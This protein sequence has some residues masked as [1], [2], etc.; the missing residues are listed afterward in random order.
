MK[1]NKMLIAIPAMLAVVLSSCKDDDPTVGIDSS[2]PA[3]AEVSYDEMNSSSS[4]IGVYWDA[5]AA[6][7]SGATSFTVQILKKKDV[8]GDAYDNT[9]S[10]TLQ[11]SDSPYDASQFT[12]L[13][14]GSKYF[15]RV[16]ANYPRSVYS[17]WAYILSSYNV[18]AKVKVGTGVMHIDP[19]AKNGPEDVTVVPFF[20]DLNLKWEEDDTAESY[21]IY[22]DDQKVGETEELSY[23]VTGLDYNT[24]YSVSVASVYSDGSE[25]K[26]DPEP[27]KTGN[28]Q[29]ITRNVG[30]THLSVNWDDVS[31]G[32]G[33][34]SRAY[35]VELSNFPRKNRWRTPFIR[36]IA[37]TVK[38]RPTVRSAAL[39]GME[40]RME[41][42]F[43]LL[44]RSHSVSWNR[45]RP[46]IS[47]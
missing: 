3:P 22:I 23:H 11:S 4:S 41:R 13:T 12:G 34:G 39:L 35:Q 5:N 10:H 17:E 45:Q 36:S 40:K 25:V 21:V 18:P 14:E 16:R 20:S 15:V 29:Q 47:A 27:T 28:I 46:T 37:W 24:S 26:A 6:L 2:M 42:T 43:C 19:N 32:A 9:V 8:G 38:P 30:P 44:R 31:G 1:I 33:A 7:K